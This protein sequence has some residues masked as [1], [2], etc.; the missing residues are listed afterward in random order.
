[1]PLMAIEKEPEKDPP[2]W[3]TVMVSIMLLAMVI[4]T[5]AGL[6]WLILTA[7]GYIIDF[8]CVGLDPDD[9]SAL[10]QDIH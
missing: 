4:G 7:G 8:A 5:I 9:A 1:M 6:I 2:L 3:M 10:C